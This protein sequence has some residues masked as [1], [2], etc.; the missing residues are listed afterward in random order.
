MPV[1]SL[2]T[3]STP[4]GFGCS[5][6]SFQSLRLRSEHFVAADPYFTRISEGWYG[7]NIGIDFKNFSQN[8]SVRWLEMCD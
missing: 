5:S 1:V 8:L 2:G 3:N 4:Q 6:M 7:D